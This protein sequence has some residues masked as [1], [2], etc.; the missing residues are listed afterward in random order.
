MK[1]SLWKASMSRPS[2]PEEAMLVMGVIMSDSK[3]FRQVYNDL[4]KKWG[5]GIYLSRWFDFSHTDY[6]NHEMGENLKRRLVLFRQSVNQEKT[7]E[8]KKI[9]WQL[10]KKYSVH[11]RRIV[12][13]DPGLLTSD[14]FILLTGKNYSHRIYL[15]EGVFADLTLVYRNGS[16]GDFDWTYGDYKDETLK[17]YLLKSRKYLEFLKS[18]PEIMKESQNDK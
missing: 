2:A 9:A 14:K 13:L 4:E 10:E 8:I 3:L 11:G 17:D 1:Q 7:K 16:F 12:N 5:R 18:E 15:G 6:Y